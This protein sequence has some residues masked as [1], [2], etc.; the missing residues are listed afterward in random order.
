MWK[1]CTARPGGFRCEKR[2]YK[3]RTTVSVLVF[4]HKC[5]QVRKYSFITPELMEFIHVQCC[6]LN[7]QPFEVDN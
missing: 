4:D 5:I 1:K 6:P 7:S 2:L 3:N